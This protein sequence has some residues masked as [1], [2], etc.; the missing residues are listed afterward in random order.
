[1]FITGRISFWQ[2]QSRRIGVR[3]GSVS[4]TLL[5]FSSA[6]QSPPRPPSPPTPPCCFTFPPFICLFAQALG[7]RPRHLFWSEGACKQRRPCGPCWHTPTPQTTRSPPNPLAGFN[8][9]GLLWWRH[10]PPATDTPAV[11]PGVDAWF[12]T[13]MWRQVDSLAWRPWEGVVGLFF[14]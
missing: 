4:N 1:M 3:T 5:R 9:E 7:W 6:L 13:V 10:T 12:E 8:K 11:A 14:F 2:P